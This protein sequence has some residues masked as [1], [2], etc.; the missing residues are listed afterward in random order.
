MKAVEMEKRNSN[1]LNH[2]TKRQKESKELNVCLDGN[3]IFHNI[4]IEGSTLIRKLGSLFN[5]LLNR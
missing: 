5:S 4:G 3:V 1:I 2:E